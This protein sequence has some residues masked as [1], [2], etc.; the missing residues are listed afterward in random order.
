MKTRT[1]D[2]IEDATGVVVTHEHLDHFDIPA[3]EWAKKKGLPVWCNGADAANLRRRGA[4]A[5]VFED[6]SL[7][8]RVEVVE[9]AH[10]TGFFGWMMGPGAGY[11]LAAPGEP[12]VYLTG[13][14]VLTPAIERA[15]DRLRPDVVVAP[16]G[17]ANFGVGADILFSRDE[18]VTLARTV[19]SWGGQVVFNHLEALD[20]CPTRRDE[21]RAQMSGLGLECHVPE[22]G[23]ELSFEARAETSAPPELVASTMSSGAY[24]WFTARLSGV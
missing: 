14:T 18:L 17:A 20:H 6:G 8:M 19:A 5:R 22:D 23:E 15:L 3:L 16:A 12:S 10:G 21:L 24:K 7:G 2:W 13:D 1:G 4:D 9:A 11:Y